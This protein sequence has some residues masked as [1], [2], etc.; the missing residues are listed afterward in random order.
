[1]ATNKKTTA[2]T[3]V[4]SE[5]SL[6]LLRQNFPTDQGFTRS[7][8]PRLGMYSQDKT[9]GRGK[10]MKVIAEAGTFYTEVQTDEE[11][12]EGKKIWQ[13]NELGDTIKG[14]IVYQRKA[15][16][17]F[18]ADTETYTSSPI[19]DD[20]N[21]IIPLFCNKAEV[22]RGTA[23]ELKARPEYQYEKDGKKRS[24][25]EDNKV[26]YVIYEGEMYQLTLRG[27]S[28]YSYI[29]YVKTG[30]PSV[31]ITE[32]SSEPMEKGQIAWNQMSFKKVRDLNQEEADMVIEKQKEIMEAIASEKQYFA[33]ISNDSSKADKEF[34][35]FQ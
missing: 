20:A 24:K 15:L 13:K 33:S 21:D 28:M 19:Y 1:M 31:C 9:E 16:R 35:D 17:Y 5:K 27:S 26:L 11:N 30:N 3:T 25:L 2:L 10:N 14:I 12:E 22:A 7:F 8:L 6:A 34:N 23:A 32:F 4:A 18:D 29:T